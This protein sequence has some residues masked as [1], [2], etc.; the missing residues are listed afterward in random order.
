MIDLI[1]ECA[2]E[3]EGYGYKVKR[4]GQYGIDLASLSVDTPQK[5]KTLGFGQGEYVIVN[6]PLVY[7]LDNECHKYIG[8]V[9]TKQLNRILESLKLNKCSRYL[10]VGIGNPDILADSLGKKVLDKIILNPLNDENNVF[11]IC[12]NIYINTGISTFET[13]YLIANTLDVDCIILIDALATRNIN[14]LGISFQLNSAGITPG[15]A[16]HDKNKKIDKESTGISCISFGVPFMIF[17]S[18]IVDCKDKDLVLA[19]KDIHE[20]V[21]I[22]SKIIA[23][24]ISEALGLEE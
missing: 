5:S 6:S 15:S 12:P 3:L 9:L 22:S 19:P 10:I 14:R 18:D 23:Y 4:L 17:A 24:A 13:V 21:E 16:M 2:S 11:K 1:D 7:D 8:K 20:N